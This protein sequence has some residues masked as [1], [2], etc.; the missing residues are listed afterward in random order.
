MGPAGSCRR[1]YYFPHDIGTRLSIDETALSHG[2]LYT[3]ITNKAAKGKKGALV[4]MIKG[5]KSDTICQI[6]CKILQRLRYKCKEITMDFANNMSV[7]ARK[8]FPAAIQVNDRFH[9][10]QLVHDALQDVRV[11]YRRQA[12]D[13]DNKAMKELGSAYQPTLL[14]NGDTLKQLLVRSRYLL[15]KTPKRWSESRRERAR[16]LFER[17]PEIKTAYLQAY[18]LNHV[19]KASTR[20]VGYSRLARGYEQVEQ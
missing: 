14:E 8:C 16:I 5:T 4:A 3:I 10:H 1:L 13:E 7:I 15:Y 6:V 9:L 12:I 11:K 18:A 19:F 17:Y 20:D 2:E